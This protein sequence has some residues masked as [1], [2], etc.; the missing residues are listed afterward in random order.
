ML[1][2]CLVLG[3]LYRGLQLVWSKTIRIG[4]TKYY[5]KFSVGDTIPRCTISVEQDN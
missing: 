2:K 3:T 5:T 4:D 1:G